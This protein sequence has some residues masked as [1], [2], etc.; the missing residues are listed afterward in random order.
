M[1]FIRTSSG[2]HIPRFLGCIDCSQHCLSKINLKIVTIAELQ[3]SKLLSIYISPDCLQMYH[4]IFIHCVETTDDS[5][6]NV[7][8]RVDHRRNF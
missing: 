7:C 4:L 6:P 3:L 1:D 2:T 5:C 8:H